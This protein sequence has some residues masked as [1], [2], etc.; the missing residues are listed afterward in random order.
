MNPVFR[1]GGAALVLA[2]AACSSP[3]PPPPPAPAPPP[4]SQ[5]DTTF[6]NQAALGGMAE[7]QFG[8]LASTKAARPAVKSFAQQMVTDHTALN[9][10]LMQLAQTKNVTLPTDLDPAHQAILARLQRERGVIFDRDYVRSQISDHQATIA[11]FQRETTDGS[12]PDVKNFANQ[13]LPQLQSHLSAAQA[14]L[15]APMPR[16]ATHHTSH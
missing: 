5:T 7:V 2:V 9:Q 16:R 1:W 6:F 14:L 8:Q 3:S 10:Q 15:P 11:L 12:D 13:A 4:I